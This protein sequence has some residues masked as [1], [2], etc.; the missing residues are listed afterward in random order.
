VNRE[1]CLWIYVFPARVNK[2]QN[3]FIRTKLEQQILH[4]LAAR[5]NVLVSGDF[6]GTLWRVKDELEMRTATLLR[7]MTF[8]L[9][10]ATRNR[11][12]HSPSGTQRQSFLLLLLL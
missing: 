6:E 12:F 9:E 11:S 7:M 5:A 4:K 8:V 10:F 1:I 3:R 2:T